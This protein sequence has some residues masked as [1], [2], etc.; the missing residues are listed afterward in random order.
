MKRRGLAMALAVASWIALTAT[1]QGQQ[2]AQL[3]VQ[4]AAKPTL[5]VVVIRP[6]GGAKVRGNLRLVQNG[7]VLRITGRI[8]NLTPGHH[9]F[10][11]HQ[12]GDSR[13]RTGDSAGG[14]FWIAEAKREDGAGDE[15][16]FNGDL[17]RI[18]AA[19]NGVAVVDV[20]LEVVSLSDL[21]GR[22]LVVHGP[23]AN[24]NE[25]RV[26]IGVVGIGNPTWRWPLDPKR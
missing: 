14:E 26:G 25:V 4:P 2:A 8:N 9:E 19:D 21:I 10:R 15:V 11:A 23:P 24:T 17:G 18:D 6:V 7:S 1:G 3:A 16:R 12:Y 13:S 5:G 22:G 20:T